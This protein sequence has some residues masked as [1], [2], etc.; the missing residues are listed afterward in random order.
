MPVSVTLG[1]GLL[2]LDGFSVLD[3]LTAPVVGELLSLLTAD[4]VVSLRIPETVESGI[5][6]GRLLGLTV[7][8]LSVTAPVS[9]DESRGC[10]CAAATEVAPSASRPAAERVMHFERKRMV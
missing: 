10:C 1:D 3:G 8:L 6:L 7:E 5:A 4:G 9:I 2:T